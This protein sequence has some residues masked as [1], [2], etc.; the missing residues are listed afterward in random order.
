MVEKTGKL[1]AIKVVKGISPD[2]NEEALRVM[3]LSPNWIPGKQR[4]NPVRVSYTIPIYF[5]L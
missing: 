5:Q 4:G 3:R 2:I 1:V